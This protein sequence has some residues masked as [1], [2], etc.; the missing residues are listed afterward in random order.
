M[1]ASRDREMSETSNRKATAVA[2]SNL[3]FIKYWGNRDARLRLPLNDS[4]SM[5]LD[6]LFTQTTVLFDDGLSEDQII[7]GEEEAKGPARER[8]VEHLD[9]VRAEAHA[10]AKARVVSRSNFPQGTGLASS[11]SGFAALTVA[12]TR[13]AGLELDE[14]ALSVLARQGSGSACRSIPGA[15]VEWIASTSSAT[16]YAHSIA[17]AEHWDLRD[18][19][20]ITTRVAKEVGSSDGH[21]AALSSPFMR[22]RLSRLPARFH[23]AKRALLGRDLP[24]LGPE[25]EAEAI[26]L[27][28]IA[29]TSRPPIFYWSPEMVRVIQAAR[30][31]HEGGLQVY[32]TLDAGPNV[33]LICE[34]RDADTVAAN[35]REVPEVQQVI[36]GGVGGAA[37]LIDTHLF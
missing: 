26:E 30:A 11:A 2:H 18:V 33:H 4:L 16:S 31:W 20:V 34:G 17:L 27:H 1:N 32:F 6:A 15:F 37:H 25:I 35:A 10:N 7:I 36:V 29:M 28:F 23:R 3:A 13:A 21:L 14:R 9:R 8:V 24:A 5:N 12:A 19:V 22:E